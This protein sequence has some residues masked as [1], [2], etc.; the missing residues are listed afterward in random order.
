MKLIHE[1]GLVSAPCPW[2]AVGVCRGFSLP[3]EHAA[4]KTPLNSRVQLPEGSF[5]FRAGGCLQSLPGVKGRN[6]GVETRVC[7]WLAMPWFWL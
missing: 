2:E 5:P 7:V 6:F 4:Q 3:T 1:Q